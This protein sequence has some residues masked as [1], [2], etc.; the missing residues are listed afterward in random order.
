MDN[1]DSPINTTTYNELKSFLGEKFPEF[2]ESYITSMDVYVR[3]AYKA[4]SENDLQSLIDN[5]HPMRSTSEH[6]GAIK[7]GKV[8]ANIEDESESLIK[9]ENLSTKS[10]LPD[11]ETLVSEY[12]QVKKV[13]A[14]D[15]T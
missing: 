14:E 12:E 1:Q 6:L 2:L 9:S 5:I 7:L 15:L 10:L 4:I 8:A 11:F 3:V 13:V